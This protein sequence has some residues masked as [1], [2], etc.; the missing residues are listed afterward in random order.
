MRIL[1]GVDGSEGGAAAL[2]W[3]T[4]L[5]MTTGDE[6]VVVH[7]VE[8]PAYDVRPL[9]LP[10]AV[11]NEVNWREALLAEV[12]GVWC[13]PLAAAGVD[14]RVRIAEGRAGPCLSDAAVQEHAGLVVTGRSAVT[15]LAELV[16]GSVTSYVTHHAPCPTVV[17]PRRAA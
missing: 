4:R 8:P 15:G 13:E 14:H 3:A 16:H 17:V 2:Q 11:L 7:A 10:R 1:V 9:G 12:E 6:I 5:A